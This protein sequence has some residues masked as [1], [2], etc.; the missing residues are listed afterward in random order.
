MILASVKSTTSR[1]AS[2]TLAF[3]Q[4]RKAGDD[5]TA[6][7]GVVRIGIDNVD[8]KFR[9]KFLAQVGV[10][11]CLL[12]PKRDTNSEAICDGFALGRAYHAEGS[13]SVRKTSMR[14]G[15]RKYTQKDLDEADEGELDELAYQCTQKNAEIAAKAANSGKRLI[16]PGEGWTRHDEEFLVNQQSGVYFSQAGERA[17]RYFRRTE[18][19]DMEEVGQPHAPKEFPNVMSAASAS[20]VRKGAKLDRAVLLNDITKIARL[21]LKFPLSFVDTPACAYALFQGL[22]TAESAQWCAENF[23]K[24][25][26]P[27]LAEKI[28]TY[29]LNE[30]QVL[31]SKTLEA[32]DAELMLSSHAFSGCGAVLAVVLGQRIAV[33]GVGRVRV[34]LLQD[35]G[36]AR[37]ILKMGLCDPAEDLERLRPLGGIVRDGVLHSSFGILEPRHEAERVLCAKHV[38]EVLQLDPK[39]APDTKTVKNSYRRLALKVHPDK[40]ADGEDKEAY[41]QAFARLDSAKDALDMMLTDDPVGSNE[42]FRILRCE[43]STRSGAAA[44]LG[45]EDA[46]DAEKASK[47][48]FKKVAKLKGKAPDYERAEAICREAIATLQRGF[49]AESLPR[50]EALLREGLLTTR[51]MGARDMREP[52]PLVTMKP[53]SASRTL[54]S[55]RCRIAILCGA[56]AE[57]SD[58]KLAESSARFIRHAKA[59]ALTW[60]TEADPSASCCSAVCIFSDTSRLD[61]PALKRQKTSAA[62]GPEGT[63]RVRH[64]LF[65]HQQ[66]KQP[67]PMARRQGAA[68]TL[69]EAEMAAL[70]AL[71]KL[72]KAEK[73]PNLFL[74]MVRELS[75]CQTAMQP[76]ALSGDL[77]WLGKG[78]QEVAFDEAVFNLGPNIIGDLVTTSRGIHIVQ[79]LA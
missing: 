40:V 3:N 46:E 12:G 67:D 63:V 29:E 49:S 21:A 43:A 70:A 8:G 51:A 50:Q 38:F 52:Y 56:T 34:A 5:N 76:G 47:A 36:P 31:L 17:A 10:G 48:L 24:K 16:P 25:L 13:D 65:S 4:Y 39:V 69:A 7:S 61:E 41:T 6:K 66:L 9:A 32:L 62:T 72:L 23:H 54:P 15:M 22:R 19:G 59:S 26:L 64:I 28:H 45:T 1:N 27:K 73:D 77:G 42:L 53:E 60:C 71:E 33:A 35:K 57:L 68:K 79:R 58:E 44:L 2:A 18:K 75:D 55:G 74:R 30:L 11:M 14:L 37:P 78:Q 20:A